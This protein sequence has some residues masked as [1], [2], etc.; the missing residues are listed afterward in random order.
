MRRS[1]QIPSTF[2]TAAPPEAPRLE[3]I[4]AA[5]A[6]LS[7][8]PS[9]LGLDGLER[10][11]AESQGSLEVA[12][13]PELLGTARL[14]AILFRRPPPWAGD[15]SGEGA[16]LERLLDGHQAI[17]SLRLAAEQ[18]DADLADS[19]RFAGLEEQALLQELRTVIG[20][21]L[22]GQLGGLPEAERDRLRGDCAAL[23]ALDEQAE[24]RRAGERDRGREAQAAHAAALDEV[25][26]EEQL[27]AVTLAL[28]HDRPVDDATL[29]QALSTFASLQ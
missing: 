23:L 25:E 11:E 8:H 15:L 18:A 10:E 13:D 29:D 24:E 17:Q 22:S 6:A 4:E 9:R 19:D 28:R 5:L 21:L 14:Y 7:E 3:A 12:V 26:A 20:G 2:L 1:Y 27:A 16:Y